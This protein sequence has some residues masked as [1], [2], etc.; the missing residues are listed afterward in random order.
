MADDHDDA[1][2]MERA[3]GVEHVREHRPAADGVQDLGQVGTHAL[4]EAGREYD[5]LEGHEGGC[6]CGL[7]GE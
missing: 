2:R 6:E 5:Y 4:A 3:G 1:R 7:K